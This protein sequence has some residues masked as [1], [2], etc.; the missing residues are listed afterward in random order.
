MAQATGM[1]SQARRPGALSVMMG[2]FAVIAVAGVGIAIVRS[3]DTGS[4]P[5]ADPPVVAVPRA[6]GNVIFEVTGKGLSLRQ[7][8]AAQRSRS[9]WRLTPTS[10]RRRPGPAKSLR[11]TADMLP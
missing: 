6:A 11:P 2:A 9:P 10:R 1:P 8:P 4:P 3:N 7:P 5:A